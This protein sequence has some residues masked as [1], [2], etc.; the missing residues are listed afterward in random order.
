MTWG[1]EPWLLRVHEV[2]PS[3]PNRFG[4][5]PDS[6]AGRSKEQRLKLL[7]SL[8]LPLD[9]GAA[10]QAEPLFVPCF[11]DV[12][13]ARIAHHVHARIAITVP[14]SCAILTWP[15]PVG[16]SCYNSNI[17]GFQRGATPTKPA[18]SEV[19]PSLPVP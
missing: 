3:K 1:F 9:P 13:V 15:V 17:S 11:Q 14:H 10:A 19:P 16:A 12:S 18:P 8:P 4:K 5:P 2:Y 6:T 7:G